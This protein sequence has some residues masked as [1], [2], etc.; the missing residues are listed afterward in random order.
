MR[1]RVPR[2]WIHVVAAV[3]VVA[4]GPS[5]GGGGG[6]GGGG[7]TP[8]EPIPAPQPSVVTVD[9]VDDAYDP[10]S[11]TI[12]PG[13]T[14][15]WVFAGTHAG[16]TVTERN[17]AFDSGFVFE[18]PGDTYERRFPDPDEGLTFE[19]SCVTHRD[20]CGMRGSVRVGNNAPPPSPGY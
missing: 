18:S 5:C 10:Q 3:A 2:I 17:G 13:D 12:Q 15:R 9:V 14:V 11:I 4:A 6:G 7:G 8:T 1:R 20:C 19:Y 16:H